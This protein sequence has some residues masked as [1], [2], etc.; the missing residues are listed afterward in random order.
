MNTTI[1]K[2]ILKDFMSRVNKLTLGRTT[3]DK[4]YG[5]VKLIKS[6]DHSK[7][8]PVC[9]RSGMTSTGCGTRKF[10][11]SNSHLIPNGSYTLT[12]LRSKLAEAIKL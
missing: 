8:N 6:A 5:K 11:V 2:Q 10:S 9:N 1:Q 4:F 7:F 3:Y 12:G